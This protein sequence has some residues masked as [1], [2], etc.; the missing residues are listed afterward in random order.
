MG[1]I[2]FSSVGKWNRILV[3]RTLADLIELAYHILTHIVCSPCSDIN[4]RCQKVRDRTSCHDFGWNV[5]PNVVVSAGSMGFTGIKNNPSNNVKQD[6]Q[7]FCF[8][9]CPRSVSNFDASGLNIA[10]ETIHIVVTGHA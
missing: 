1:Y 2:I 6:S 7:V 9:S 3:L 5:V 8:L 4:D 10:E